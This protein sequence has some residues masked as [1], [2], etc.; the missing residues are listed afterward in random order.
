MKN[1]IK[2]LSERR[3]LQSLKPETVWSAQLDAAITTVAAEWAERTDKAVKPYA[4]SIVSGMHL[5]NDNLDASHSISQHI[6][7]PEGSCWH[8]IMHRMEGDYWNSKYWYR[9]VGNLS[10]YRDLHQAV[11]RLAAQPGVMESIGSGRAKSEIEALVKANGWDPYRFVDAVET[12]MEKERNDAAIALME[13]IQ[14]YELALLLRH[15]YTAAGE[16][17][18]LDVNF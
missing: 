5:W 10:F 15:C 6:E 7:T 1:I 16:T 11:C 2:Q 3:P 9:R 4:L 13:Q 12:Q 17:A 18:D 14:R 8:A